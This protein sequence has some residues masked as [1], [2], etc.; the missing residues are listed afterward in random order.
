MKKLIVAAVCLLMVGCKSV[1]VPTAE[2]LFND[3]AKVRRFGDLDFGWVPLTVSVDR[4]VGTTS[5]LF[6]NAEAVKDVRSGG[7]YKAG[8]ALKLVTWRQREDPHWFGGRIPG[9][10]TS[11]EGVAFES[12]GRSYGRFAGSPLV[13][14]SGDDAAR[15]AA[16]VGMKVARLP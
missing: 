2:D 6:G 11:V 15:E 8:A 14:T 3:E 9:E 12:G 5:I 4:G 13:K 7:T 1:K 16:I 10:V